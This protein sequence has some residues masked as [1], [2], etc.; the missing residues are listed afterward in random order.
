MRGK[1]NVFESLSMTLMQQ[2]AGWREWQECD[3]SASGSTSGEVGCRLRCWRRWRSQSR[4]IIIP[5]EPILWGTRN[6]F[7]MG[8]FCYKRVATNRGLLRKKTE[9]LWLGTALPFTWT[10][11]AYIRV[12]CKQGILY[13]GGV[14]D[15]TMLTI[16]ARVLLMC[17][18]EDSLHKALA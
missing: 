7:T 11:F 6:A 1:K 5:E 12:Y 2:E 16:Y 15:I 13:C 4:H 9:D 3:V 10:E 17:L 14:V 8:V 18:L